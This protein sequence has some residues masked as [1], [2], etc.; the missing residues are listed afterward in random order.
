M[1]QP[2]QTT[3][4]ATPTAPSLPPRHPC[5]HHGSTAV[6]RVLVASPR[7]HFLNR[8]PLHHPHVTRPSSLLPPGQESALPVA[9]HPTSYQPPCQNARL[10][11][12]NALHHL[13][14]IRQSSQ[15]LPA[16]LATSARTPR[17]VKRHVWHSSPP[18]STLSANTHP[19]AAQ[20]H[21]LVHPRPIHRHITALVSGRLKRHLQRNTAIHRGANR[22]RLHAHCQHGTRSG[23]IR[24][25]RGPTA[26]QHRRRAAAGP[27]ERGAGGAAA[28]L[29]GRVESGE[30][31]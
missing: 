17:C 10:L 19:T 30:R 14:S 12:A 20:V 16:L 11:H 26:N 31:H 24:R 18:L 6:Q 27:T 5:A 4:R 3:P 21:P 2:T 28:E 9:E 13:T 22:A 15:W 7:F 25:A 29:C 8:T 1:T 23:S